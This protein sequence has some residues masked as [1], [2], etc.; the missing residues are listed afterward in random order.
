[1]IRKIWGTHPPVWRRVVI[2]EK[3][4]FENLHQ[5]IQILFGWQNAHLHDFACEASPNS[6]Q[7]TGQLAGV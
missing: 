5:V 4:S 7:F 3:L 6:L 2:P 1:M